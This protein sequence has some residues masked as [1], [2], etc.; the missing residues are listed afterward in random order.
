MMLLGGIIY[1]MAPRDPLSIRYDRAARDSVSRAITRRGLWLTLWVRDD[2]DH[3]AAF[4][5]ACYYD[6]RI[7]LW[8]Q[9]GGRDPLTGERLRNPGRSHALPLPPF[10]HV[11][12]VAGDLPFQRV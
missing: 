3:L 1:R 11:P 5:R 10:P 7:Y 12:G 4:R 9:G 2:A 8:L 6:K